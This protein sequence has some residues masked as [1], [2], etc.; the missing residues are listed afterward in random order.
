VQ[1]IVEGEQ[2][3]T[4]Y[5]PYK[6]SA[7]AAVEMAVA[8]GRGKSVKSIATATVNNAT[9]KNIP[10]VLLPSVAVTVGNIKSTL[11]KD[12]LYTINQICIPDLRSACAKAGLTP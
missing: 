10:A 11:V 3:M 12:G 8:L 2:Y 7:D 4:V 9:N 1:R 5:K 6:R